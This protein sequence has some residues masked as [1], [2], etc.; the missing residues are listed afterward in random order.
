MK[1]EAR[2]IYI[3]MIK[4]RLELSK[5]TAIEYGNN[6]INY[7]KRDLNYMRSLKDIVSNNKTY[8]SKYLDEQR[9]GL[10]DAKV[11]G[12]GLKLHP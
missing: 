2:S 1:N 5:N 12:K 9:K 11:L 4:S 10:L 6:W 3:T 7:N 8:F